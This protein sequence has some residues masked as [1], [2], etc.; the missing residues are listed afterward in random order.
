MVE[1]GGIMTQISNK[2]NTNTSFH[3]EEP[4]PDPNDF[5]TK[6]EEIKNRELLSHL[7]EQQKKR[8]EILDRITKEEEIKKEIEEEQRKRKLISQKAYYERR[9]ASAKYRSMAYNERIKQMLNKVDE[10]MR[11]ISNLDS[12]A[13]IKDQA[14]KEFEEEILKNK[15]KK[16]K[17]NKNEIEKLA[18]LNEKNKILRI[19]N[20][21]KIEERKKNELLKNKKLDKAKKGKNTKKWI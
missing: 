15:K 10:Y 12:I 5:G 18:Q 7:Y 11:K 16:R 8:R 1:N 6:D 2:N 14:Q 3:M 20:K 17:V 21:K 13:K 4:P 9:N 19:D